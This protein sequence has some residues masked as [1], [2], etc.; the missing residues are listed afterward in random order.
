MTSKK[1]GSA[2][3]LFFFMLTSP[4]FA[5][6]IDLDKF[7]SR[8]GITQNQLTQFERSYLESD[9]GLKRLTGLRGQLAEY[10]DKEIKTGDLIGFAVDFSKKM[11]ELA[12][13]KL[14][15]IG[16][17]LGLNQKDYDKA[18]DAGL[19]EADGKEPA[20]FLKA[21]SGSLIKSA[22]PNRLTKDKALALA[23][24][25]QIRMDMVMMKNHLKDEDYMRRLLG[26]KVFDKFPFEKLSRPGGAI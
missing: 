10:T 19:D 22:Q 26:E 2:A 4:A 3:I 23:K 12:Q 17:G 13:T 14:R 6:D 1:F 21:M 9:L 24:A 5:A 16:G 20:D 7:C 8:Y 18:L 11:D 15:E 25:I